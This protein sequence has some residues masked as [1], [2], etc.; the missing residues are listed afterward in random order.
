MRLVVQEYERK[1]QP[2][3][4]IK[5]P[6]ESSVSNGGDESTFCAEFCFDSVCHEAV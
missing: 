6:F 1:R 4:L 5:Q 2:M 3:G